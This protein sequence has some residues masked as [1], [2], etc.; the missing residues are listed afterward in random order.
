MCLGTQMYVMRRGMVV[1][2]WRFLNRGK[3]FGEDMLINNSELQVR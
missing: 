2:L 1:R 3:V